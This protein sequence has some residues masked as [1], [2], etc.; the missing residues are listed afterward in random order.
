MSTQ[1]NDAEVMTRSERNWS[2]QTIATVIVASSVLLAMT[3]S[4]QSNGLAGRAQQKPRYDIQNVGHRGVG[5]GA[6]AY[7]LTREQETGKLIATQFERSA[8]VI[9]DEVVNDY[10]AQLGRSIASHSD[11][12]VPLTIKVIKDDETNALSLPGGYVYVQT[13]LILEADNEAQL[14]GVIAH[15]I[16]HVAARH[17][18]RR[19]TRFR[20]LFAVC[21][22]VRP[23]YNRDAE[24][25]A[26]L[27]GLQYQY[28]SGYDPQEF[29]RLFEKLAGPDTKT[30]FME[31]VFSSYPST[32]ERIRR[33]QG[34]IDQ[35]LP[36][37]EQYVI[38][39]ARFEEMKSRVKQ[40][41]NSDTAAS[42]NQSRFGSALRNSCRHC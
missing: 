5:N 13:G 28:L 15:E 41:R 9:T 40:L 20:S 33:A 34:T 30:S 1:R 38:D 23:K 29:I 6:N 35:Y 12:Q 14:A 8:Q 16:A 19:E 42:D 31:R 17:G 7:S 3:A 18:T 37:K 25:E 21:S 22:F 36:V 4:A 32:A 11:L 26:D 27:L 2:W 24:R 10:I 39:T